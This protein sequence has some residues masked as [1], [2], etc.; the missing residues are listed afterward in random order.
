MK[1]DRLKEFVVLRQALLK[2]KAELEQRL[3]QLDRALDLNGATT[4]PRPSHRPAARPK[5]ARNPVSL[6]GAVLEV[7][8][9]KGLT[10]SEIMA[11]LKKIGYRFTAKDPMNFLN[12]VLYTGKVFKNEGGKFSPR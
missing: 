4:P 5:T 8:K 12:T 6:K 10:K 2:E 9:N 3:E 7:T 1:S 11:A